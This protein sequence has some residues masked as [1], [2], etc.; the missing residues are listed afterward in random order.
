MNGRETV[1]QRDLSTVENL[2]LSAYWFSLN[3]HW[4]A[5]LSVLLPVEVL[6]RSPGAQKALYLG[7]L[8]SVGSLL[9]MVVQPVAGALVNVAGLPKVGCGIS[10][11]SERQLGG[12]ARA[13]GVAGQP[14]LP[15]L[16]FPGLGQV[17]PL[18]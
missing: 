2:Y 6:S 7:L 9:G 17:K 15:D 16:L 10:G 12:E 18:A 11:Q 13:A 4:G 1:P 8:A 14:A 3:F 5:M